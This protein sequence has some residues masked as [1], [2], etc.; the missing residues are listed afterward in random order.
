MVPREAIAHTIRHSNIGTERFRRVMEWIIVE[1]EGG[2]ADDAR[3]PG[4]KTRWGITEAVARDWG[5]PGPMRE[6]PLPRAL[7]V[8][9]D[10]YWR[11]LRLT[12]VASTDVAAE[13]MD[14]GINTGVAQASKFAQEAVNILYGGEDGEGVA[15]DGV[16]G[17]QTLHALGYWTA[18]DEAAL[19]AALNGF[20]FMHY[21]GLYRRGPR[22]RYAIRSWVRRTQAKE[23]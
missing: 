13:I 3:D 21:L 9:F 16:I 2:F 1:H 8:Y 15:V 5:Y 23:F 22:L 7:F 6:F 10:A 12:Q 18:K 11:P 17:P 19:L 14:S 20:Q 4:G